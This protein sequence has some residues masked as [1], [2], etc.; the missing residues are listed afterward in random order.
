MKTFK[1]LFALLFGTTLFAQNPELKIYY[2]KILEI[3][4][5]MG[6][7]Y[8]RVDED[9]VEQWVAIA[10]KPVHVNDIIGYDKTTV[11][12]DFKS[13]TLNKVFKEIIFAN[14]IYVP[15]KSTQ[16]ATMKSM[17]LATPVNNPTTQ[18]IQPRKDFVKKEFYTI[19]EIHT[20]ANELENQTISLKA[21]VRKISNQIM[22][23]DW[24]H[25]SDGTGNEAKNTDDFVVTSNQTTAKVGDSVI[26]T[27][28]VIIN[29]DF[30]YGYFYPVII[31]DVVLK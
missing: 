6:Y 24:I 12:H 14:E 16:G 18:T 13:K 22:K 19:K 1:I 10:E 11:M 29:K 5:V 7:D 31:E 8:L 4:K 21:T 27:G 3:Q 25:L 15:Q 20:F 17:L 2:G 28:K 26:A 9:G 23:R 30:G